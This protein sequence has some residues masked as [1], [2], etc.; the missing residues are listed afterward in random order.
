MKKAIQKR[1]EKRAR[2]RERA[3][4]ARVNAA[5]G[6]GVCVAT[7]FTIAVT[8]AAA[9]SM[10]AATAT[11]KATGSFGLV[12]VELATAPQISTGVAS[13]GVLT[14]TG[15]V[16]AVVYGIKKLVDSAKLDDRNYMSD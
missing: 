15:V 10:A 11:A 3:R 7:G 8:T 16:A 4:R 6:G 9:P 12:G 13:A 14:P 2:A 1:S 5:F